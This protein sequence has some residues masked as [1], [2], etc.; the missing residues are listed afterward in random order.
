MLLQVN[1]G[2]ASDV[3]DYTLARKLAISLLPDTF[4]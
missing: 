3:D 2:S 1:M 4:L